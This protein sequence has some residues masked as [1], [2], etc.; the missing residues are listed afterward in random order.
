MR[1]IQQIVALA[2]VISLLAGPARALGF[3]RDAEIEQL[4]ADYPRPLLIAAGLNPDRVG[5]ALVNN[6]SLNAFV[7]N[8]QNMYIFTGHILEA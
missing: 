6:K 5:I 7:A 8:G 4:M 1:F 2:L 3:I